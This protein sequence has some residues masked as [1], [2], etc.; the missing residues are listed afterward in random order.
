V[1]R[2]LAADA[3]LSNLEVQVAGL[4]DAFTE[5]THEADAALEVA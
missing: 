1:R 4:A 3:G 2:L 5:L